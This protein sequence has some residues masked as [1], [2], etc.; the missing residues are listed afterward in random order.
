M[1]S[2]PLEENKLGTV[3]FPITPELRQSAVEAVEELIGS[4]DPKQ[5]ESGVRLLIAMQRANGAS[6]AIEAEDDDDRYFG[7]AK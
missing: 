4:D 1:P 5:V 2:M 3:A 6:K 7:S